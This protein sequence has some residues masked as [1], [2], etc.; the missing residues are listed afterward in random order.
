MNTLEELQA[1]SDEQLIEKLAVEVMGWEDAS[2]FEGRNKRKEWKPY[3]VNPYTPI[4]GTWNPL[5]DWNHWREVEEK[6]MSNDMRFVKFCWHH[7]RWAMRKY[8]ETD[9]RTRCVIALLAVQ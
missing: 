1:L 4:S 2:Y 3:G 7:F 9:L 8:I 6:L 5:T